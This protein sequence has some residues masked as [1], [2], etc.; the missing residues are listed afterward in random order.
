MGFGVRW[1]SD[2][3]EHGGG[4]VHRWRP[5]SYSYSYLPPPRPRD[6]RACV[7]VAGIWLEWLG[8]GVGWCVRTGD[9]MRFFVGGGS[10][11]E[12]AVGVNKRQWK[13]QRKERESL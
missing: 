8:S 4:R 7:C 6:C 12:L 5:R 3:E 1:I 2:Y 10:G 9:D 13:D 11:C